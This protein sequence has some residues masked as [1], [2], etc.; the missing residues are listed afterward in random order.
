MCKATNAYYAKV[1]GPFLP[2]KSKEYTYFIVSRAKIKT[3]RSFFLKG[4]PLITTR[5][6][7]SLSNYK[8][9]RNFGIVHSRRMRTN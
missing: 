6:L 9:S 2:A 4:R 1:S 3:M 5:G 7:L 8:L